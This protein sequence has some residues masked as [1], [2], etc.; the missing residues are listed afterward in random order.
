MNS[1]K[2]PKTGEDVS[3]SENYGHEEKEIEDDYVN[4]NMERLKTFPFLAM[5]K[6]SKQ[7]DFGQYV[8]HAVDDVSFTVE[9]HEYVGI[10]GASGAGKTTLL[11]ML[12]GLDKPTS[13]LIRTAH[14]NIVPMH[15]ETLATFRTIN[16]GVIFQ[17]YNLISSL[18]AGENVFFALRM[19]G[20]DADYAEKRVKE[21][22]K[23]VGL[24]ERMDHLPHQLSAGEQQRVA[25]ARA[26]A[27]N[28]P[29][30]LADE[31]TANL[32]KKNADYI[33][34]LFENFRKEGKTIVVA[35]H[36]DRLIKHAHR[37][38]EMECGKII[39]DT[40]Q[41]QIDYRDTETP[42]QDEMDE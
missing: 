21:V 39:S 17:S 1:V 33:G 11:H 27:N 25:I 19:A 42:R 7:F 16:I 22:I 24:E 40:R 23:I 31:P 37:I 15:E 4:P 10:I 14:I 3:E 8:I 29:I 9:E 30:I 12:A 2:G 20:A 34:T 38:M 5:E 36:D 6:V 32:D 18:T 41:S 13:G 26:L 35:T 28:P